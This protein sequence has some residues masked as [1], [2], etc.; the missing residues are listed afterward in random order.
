MVGKT[1]KVEVGVD[2][3]WKRLKEKIMRPGNDWKSSSMR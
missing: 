2:T 3:A 1:G